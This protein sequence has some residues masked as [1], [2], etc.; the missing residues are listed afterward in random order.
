MEI[1]FCK[2]CG[3]QIDEDS[4]FCNSCG[5][6][7][8]SATNQTAQQPQQQQYGQQYY[9]QHG[10]VSSDNTKLFS[11]LSYIWILFVVGL[12]AD[13]NN[14]KVKYHANQG[15]ILLIFDIVFYVI[16]SI[17]IAI[18]KYI[19]VIIPIIGGLTTSLLTLVQWGIPFAFM[20]IGIINAAKGEEKPLPII[21]NFTIIK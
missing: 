20:I 3:K 12:I 1:M 17:P 4:N 19:F 6:S 7:T 16:F 15:L 14:Q 13:P 10:A 21:G 5:T 11:I 2:K 9:Q 18:M 8:R